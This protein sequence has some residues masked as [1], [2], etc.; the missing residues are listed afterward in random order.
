MIWVDVMQTAILC[1]ADFFRSLRDGILPYLDVGGPQQPQSSLLLQLL[2]KASSNDKRFV[3]E[4]AQGALQVLTESLDPMQLLNRLM[5]YTAHRNPKAGQTSQCCIC[6]LLPS[7]SS[8]WPFLALH[9]SACHVACMSWLEAWK[10]MQS[11][12][13][14]LHCKAAPAH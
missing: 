4:E 10:C 5:P 6:Q 3:V 7:S 13:C 12:G 2:L 1:S 8:S 11:F 14:T 9:K